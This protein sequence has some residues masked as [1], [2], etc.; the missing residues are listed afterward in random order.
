MERSEA[1]A[2]LIERFQLKG[3]LLEQLVIRPGALS[4]PEAYIDSP[5]LMRFAMD[6]SRMLAAEGLKLDIR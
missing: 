4:N 3:T 1:E 2:E 6:V 5:S